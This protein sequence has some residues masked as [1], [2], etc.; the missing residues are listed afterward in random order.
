MPVK[1]YRKKPVVIEACEWTG[2]MTD[3]LMK[4]MSGTKHFITTGK[5]MVIETLEGNMEASLGDFIIKGIHG[6]LYPCKP[7]IFWKTYEQ[8]E[9]DEQI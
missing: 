3:E 8:I 1:K 6:E 2:E 9:E 4:F 5:K 7:D